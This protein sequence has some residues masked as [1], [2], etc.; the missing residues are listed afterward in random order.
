MFIIRPTVAGWRRMN[1]E[2]RRYE[3]VWKEAPSLGR[4]RYYVKIMLVRDC[5]YIEPAISARFSILRH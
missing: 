1:K 5:R 4:K 2:G 3:R